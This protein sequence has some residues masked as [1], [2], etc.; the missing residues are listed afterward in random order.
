M[1]LFVVVTLVTVYIMGLS[2]A[3]PHLATSALAERKDVSQRASLQSGY[4][5]K[6]KS[7]R[8]N[9]LAQGFFSNALGYL[10]Q[11]KERNTDALS[12]GFFS[13]ALGYLKQLK[14]RNIN[15]DALSQGF[16]SD[17]LGYL[18]RLMN[19]RKGLANAQFGGFGG[20]PIVCIRAPCC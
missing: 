16:F 6:M 18:K 15:A 3:A 11:L 2:M 13:G 1:K 7:E 4:L 19:Q 5:S 9:A 10:K 20:C 8:K 17:A 12:Q 14:Q